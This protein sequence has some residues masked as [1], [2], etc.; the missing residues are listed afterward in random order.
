MYFSSPMKYPA[1]CFF[2]D[3]EKPGRKIILEAKAESRELANT[4]GI[5]R[6]RSF[7]FEN[8]LFILSVNLISRN[9]EF[10]TINHFNRDW[11]FWTYED[12]LWPFEFKNESHGT[13]NYW[14]STSDRVEDSFPYDTAINDFYPI[15]GKQMNEFSLWYF[16]EYK[17]L[18]IKIEK[19]FFLSQFSDTANSN[20]RAAGEDVLKSNHGQKPLTLS[21]STVKL[22]MSFK[23][24][25]NWYFHIF[26]DKRLLKDYWKPWKIHLWSFQ[27]NFQNRNKFS[28]WQ[29]K[30]T[31]WSWKSDF[32]RSQSNR[33]TVINNF[34]QAILIC[35]LWA[36]KRIPWRY[37]FN[38]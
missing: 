28:S 21:F 27:S 18:L 3:P 22:K 32:Q 5:Y 34:I 20:L 7:V 36:K 30:R 14:F 38:F 25:S 13:S 6:R 16:E 12:P 9:I 10:I 2:V 15:P 17:N 35:N 31:I 4:Y 23:L 26:F 19:E 33:I 37:Y 29:Y 8:K 1:K 24:F 11:N